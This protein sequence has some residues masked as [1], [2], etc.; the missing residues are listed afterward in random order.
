MLKKKAMAKEKE[1]ENIFNLLNEGL[2]LEGDLQTDKDI[3]INGTLKGNMTTNGKIIIGPVANITGQTKAPYIEIF[4]KLTGNI[5]SEG[6]VIL[7]SKSIIEGTI[8][9]H[10]LIVEPGAQFN[11]ECKMID[12][13]KAE[14]HPPQ[15]PLKK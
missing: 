14:P 15:A 2:T 3:R 9:T 5:I 10:T 6:S 11:G 4:G 13:K 7:K 8:V 1:T 12:K